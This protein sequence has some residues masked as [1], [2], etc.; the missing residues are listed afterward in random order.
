MKAK[1]I[2]FG[3]LL[4]LTF[5]ACKKEEKQEVTEV[6]NDVYRFTLNAVIKK[7][8]TFQ[9]FYKD[10]NDNKAPFEETKSVSVDLKGSETA[11]NIV[12]NLP[13][14]VY[15]TEL[16]I[17]F[18]FNKEQK[19]IIVNEFKVEF[20]DKNFIVKGA[21]FFDYFIAE[22][23]FVSFDKATST[24]KPIITADGT[25]DPMFFSEVTLN[26]EMIKLSK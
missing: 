12:F 4:T 25:Y 23:A 1:K 8:D 13:Q 11:Q 18:G 16:R 7:D 24:A 17:D 26:A 20:L 15:P 14:D 6:K 21:S 5:V 3:L 22:K 2:L 19:D 10:S 9:L